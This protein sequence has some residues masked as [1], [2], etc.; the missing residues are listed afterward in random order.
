MFIKGTGFFLFKG[1]CMSQETVQ[2]APRHKT[3]SL[4]LPGVPFGDTQLL[5]RAPMQRE[6]SPVCKKLTS[7]LE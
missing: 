3:G 5:L 4:I 1:C 2:H 7:A 6:G